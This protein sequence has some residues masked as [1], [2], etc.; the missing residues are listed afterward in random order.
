MNDSLFTQQSLQH[1]SWPEDQLKFIKKCIAA[2]GQENLWNESFEVNLNVNRLDGILAKFQGVNGSIKKTMTVKIIPKEGVVYF[3]NVFDAGSKAV[4]R[5]GNVQVTSANGSIIES[6]DHRKTF[7]FLKKF[8]PW[9]K[10]D[11]IYFRGYALT[12]YYSIPAILPLLE[13]ISEKYWIHK[14]RV[15]RG[16][17]VRFPK[18][19]DSH[20]T[21]QCFYFGPEGLLYR[22]DYR[23][24]IVLP[25]AY[26]SHFTT[27]Y[28]DIKGIKVSRKRKV[29]FRFFKWVTSLQVLYIGMSG[30]E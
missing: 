10:L 1:V 7:T 22:H 29:F 21:L 11:A 9:S 8:L 19:F 4:Y 13:F 5:K 16:F 14:G 3:D 12:T 20:S 30:I 24:D 23:L 17:W 2:H 27:D 15:Y 18:G 26:G 25:P 28:T 6:K